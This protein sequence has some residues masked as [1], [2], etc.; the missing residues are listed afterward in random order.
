MFK[1]IWLLKAQPGVSHSAFREWYETSHAVIS[2]KYFGHLLLVYRRNYPVEVNG[3]PQWD[4]DCITEWVM[5]SEAAFDEIM[6]I[7][8]DP[9]L[10]KLFAADSEN[11]L[12]PNTVL[13]KCDPCG[14]SGNG[15]QLVASALESRGVS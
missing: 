15:D 3:A 5:E 14:R 13:I 11:V 7:F 4:Y 9:V 10:G 12:D 2:E 1:V 8:N 6:S